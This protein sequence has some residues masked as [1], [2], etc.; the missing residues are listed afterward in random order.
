MVDIPVKELNQSK[1]ICSKHFLPGDFDVNKSLLKSTAVPSINISSKP[2]M[3]IIKNFPAHTN[4]KKLPNNMEKNNDH[5]YCNIKI[6][7]NFLDCNID[8]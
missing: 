5:D 8:K 2:L 6:E 3:N 4:I 1:Y 7:G